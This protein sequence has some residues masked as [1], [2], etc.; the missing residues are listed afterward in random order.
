MRQ[1]VLSLFLVVFSLPLYAKRHDWDNLA[2]LK[3]GNKISVELWAEAPVEGRF[4]SATESILRVRTSNSQWGSQTLE[5]PRERIRL[6][7]QIRGP[8]PRDPVPAMR[9][10]AL[11]GAAGGATIGV[12][13]DVKGGP[14]AGINWLVD[15][16]AG[17]ALGF[18]VDCGIVAGTGVVTVFRHNRVIYVDK[19]ATRRAR[20]RLFPARVTR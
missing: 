5:L 19:R 7:R 10:A 20:L 8:Q 12:V 3:P 13:R 4:D 1:T 17:A 18:F 14:A 11:I 2:K 15:G 16:I 9:N 6:V